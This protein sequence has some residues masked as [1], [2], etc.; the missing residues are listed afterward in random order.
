M[1]RLYWIAGIAQEKFPW[2]D[3]KA[4]ND[5]IPLARADSHI[6]FTAS[7]F[8]VGNANDRSI[9]LTTS[10]KYSIAWEGVNV[11]LSWLLRNPQRL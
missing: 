11:D 1:Y 9:E 4:H 7:A 2:M 8:A 10:S 5:T 3:A 6:S